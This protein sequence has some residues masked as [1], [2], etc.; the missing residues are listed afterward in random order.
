MDRQFIRVRVVDRNEL[1]AGIHQRRDKRQISRKAIELCNHQLGFVSLAGRKRLLQFRPVTALAAL[2]LGELVDEL[3]PAPVQVV[4]DGL[5]L[6]LEAK[7]GLALPI[8]TDTEITD[9]FPSMRRHG[10]PKAKVVRTLYQRL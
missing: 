3:P 6:R 7:A 8:R 2:D 5:P 1:H 4:E 10:A 9:E